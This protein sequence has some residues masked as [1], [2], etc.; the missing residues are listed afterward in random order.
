MVNWLN[1][2]FRNP[3]LMW[4][5]LLL[6]SVP[7]IIHLINRI[8][9]K[10]IRWAAM[11]FLLKSQKRNRRRLI[12]EQLLLLALRCFLVLLAGLLVAR[13]VS[14]GIN[15][16][17]QQDTWHYAVLDDTLS[18]SD[19]WQ[20][21][22]KDTNCFDMSKAFVR[23]L[24]KT[25][26]E[27]DS[28]QHLRLVLLS[29]PENALFDGQLNN[30]SKRELEVILDKPDLQPSLRHIKPA[31]GF[32]AADK[33]FSEHT[34]GKKVF[35]FISDFREKDWNATDETLAKAMEAVTQKGNVFLM[36]CAHPFRGENQ[37]VVLN[38]DN[39]CITDLQ[40]ETRIVSNEG[41]P[42]EFVV[43]IK[44]FS[45][46]ERKNVMLTV[47]VDGG[48]RFEA[49]QP[50]PNIPVGQY[51]HKF[52]LGF[53]KEGPN[54]ITARLEDEKNGISADNIRHAVVEVRKRIP[55]LV[56]D[57]GF[58][59]V[60][61]EYSDTR[62]VRTA[63][64]AAK[65]Y[66][67]VPKGADALEKDDLSAYPS[68]FLLNVPDNKISEKGLKNLEEYVRKGGRIAFF[69]GDR[70]QGGKYNELLYKSGTGLFP[71][72]LAAKPSEKLNKDDRAAQM[73]NGQ[74]KVYV[75]DKDHAITRGLLSP[76]VHDYLRF[77][78]ID[79]YYP[80]LPRFQWANKSVEELATL[81]SRKEL[82]DFAVLAQE[83]YKKVEVAAEDEKN[84]KYRLG[85]LRRHD[86]IRRVLAGGKYVYELALALDG[87]LLDRGDPDKKDPKRPNLV[88]FWEQPDQEELKT[89]F[90]QLRDAVKYGDPLIVSRRFGK[91]QVVAV[92]TSASTRWN[93]WAGGGFAS[94][95]FPMVISDLQ[96][97]LTGG[98]EESN[99][100]IGTPVSFTLE[101][102]RYEAR[103]H[104]Q[105]HRGEQDKKEKPKEGKGDG[106][107]VDLGE[108]KVEPKDKQLVFDFNEAKNTGLYEFTLY[109][110]GEPSPP[111]ETRV[112]VY[113]VD[114]ENE[115]DLRRAGRDK[116]E[117]AT[118]GAGPDA[119][120]IR[121]LVGESRLLGG[122]VGLPE[123]LSEK[124]ADFSVTP[125]IYL[126]FI[127][128]LVVEQM[129]AV[130]LSFH[131]RGGASE[132]QLPAQVLR[133]QG[134]AA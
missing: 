23:A 17:G 60:D 131:I 51:E 19:R 83:L 119:G 58:P 109:P 34:E 44:N 64:G 88:E 15:K 133:S 18:M 81:P 92:L 120:K 9:F 77:L 111:P 67:V 99:R 112:Y 76:E 85:L 45:P 16:L 91:G 75:R 49:T 106:L 22:A 21:Q 59:D 104:R 39:I 71:V 57:G 35:H 93:E 40:P 5:G 128:V 10:R 8:R 125:W 11:E 116:L 103:M 32:A 65:G 1:Q 13:F 72:P 101:A 105:F 82:A 20:E 127:V 48:E 107:T 115:S 25:A 98:N 27:E 110:R 121:L 73:G 124:K 117:R 79:Q 31:V 2:F 97:Y 70:V 54:H 4:I 62:F 102:D 69:L 122:D 37:Q 80:A 113:N 3:L 74:F 114:T 41:Q 30:D 26:L 78:M 96:K 108:Q 6:I 38:H 129:L 89:N 126:L 94:F 87:L 14:A 130:H 100:T 42:I 52:Q 53:T 33:Y 24:V 118:T 50:I 68:I 61:S 95:T 84:A 132:A 36:D 63:L 86:D 55:V 7:I 43:T 66:D 12:L 47:N 90:E 29:D 28:P 46:S 134:A 123:A 56:V